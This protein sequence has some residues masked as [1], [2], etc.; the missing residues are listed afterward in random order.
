MIEIDFKNMLWG[1]N[2]A[3]ALILGVQLYNWYPGWIKED[4]AFP[5]RISGDCEYDKTWA[6]DTSEIRAWR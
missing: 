3:A 1:I 2:S 5:E 6:L 4:E